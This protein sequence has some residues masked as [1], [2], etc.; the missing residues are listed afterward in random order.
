MFDTNTG[1]CII[2]GIPAQV[3]QALKKPT[4]PGKFDALFALTSALKDYDCWMNDNECWQ[5]GEQLEKSIAILATAWR[6][7]LK[8]S[9]TELGIDA[10]FTR[11][12]I[13]ALLEQFE[14][15][16]KECEATEDLPFKWRP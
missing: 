16:L 5:P 14:Q 8:K 10:E 7:L 13:E 6:S 15:E 12:G 9:D 3:K 4:G 11:P 1:N 2:D